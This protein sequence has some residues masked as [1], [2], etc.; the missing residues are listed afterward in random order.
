MEDGL[1]TEVKAKEAELSGDTDTSASHSDVPR[2]TIE[3]P[4]LSLCHKPWW[5]M[6]IIL[7]RSDS[8]CQWSMQTISVVTKLCGCYWACSVSLRRREGHAAWVFLQ[9]RALLP[10]RDLHRGAGWE[11]RLVLFFCISCNVCLAIL[12]LSFVAFFPSWKKHNATESSRP[13]NTLSVDPAPAQ[14][15]SL[16]EADFGGNKA[17]KVKQAK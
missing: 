8:A 7:I 4:L 15:T 3:N 5:K 9:Q 2:V 13:K 6:E 14:L 1:L 17:R 16:V 10:A 12:Q 11:A